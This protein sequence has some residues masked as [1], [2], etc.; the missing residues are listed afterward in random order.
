MS[1]VSQ[2]LSVLSG[3]T[4]CCHLS[5]S[6]LEAWPTQKTYI[7]IAIMDV[8]W[9]FKSS[10]GRISEFVGGNFASWISKKQVMA[11]RSSAE[12]KYQAIADATCDL[13]WIRDLPNELHLLLSSL[14]RLYFHNKIVIHIVDNYVFHG[15]HQAHQGGSSSCLFKCDREQDH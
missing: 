11:S 7:Q 14:I 15:M 10:L 4:E 5:A 6:L 2:F 9:I 12:S 8:S 1:V 3:I 13:I